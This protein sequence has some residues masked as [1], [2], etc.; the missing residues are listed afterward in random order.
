M[1]IPLLKFEALVGSSLFYK[2]TQCKARYA[3]K[4]LSFTNGRSFW[5]EKRCLGK[6]LEE[7]LC[8]WCMKKEAAPFD[9]PN[10]L[11]Q[12]Q[13]KVGQAYFKKSVLYGSP[14]F[15][16]KAELEDF[17][18]SPGD[19]NCAIQAQR[20]AIIGT[21]M[22][23]RKKKDEI[24]TATPPAKEEK[25]KKPRAPRKKKEEAPVPAPIIVPTQTTTAIAVESSEE[26]LEALE[27]V[28]IPVT[29][30]IVN[31]KQYWYDSKKSKVYEH[32]KDKGV[33]KY[34]GRFDSAEDTIVEFPD[35]DVDA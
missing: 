7:D 24:P 9:P 5:T 14:W 19:L 11:E 30:K 4:E 25:P 29:L 2:M 20:D 3:D 15:L 32:K 13:G 18:I 35:S 1:K 31:G 12:Y 16:K 34:L 22:P 23:P 8:K 27:V 21:Q 33:G 6:A 26:P 28:K 17:E 10:Q